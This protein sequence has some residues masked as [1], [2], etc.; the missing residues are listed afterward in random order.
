MIVERIVSY[1]KAKGIAIS[2]FEK[3]LHLGNTTLSKAYKTGGSIGT[4]KL[5]KIISYCEDLSPLWLV[6]GEGDMLVS[7]QEQQPAPD[8]RGS[9]E[10][11]NSQKKEAPE[12]EVSVVNKAGAVI[13]SDVQALKSIISS[14]VVKALEDIK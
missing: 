1:L 6:T 13:I 12:V 11:N 5:E 9:D 14:A 7:S 3:E 4:D 2:T 8:P 10:E